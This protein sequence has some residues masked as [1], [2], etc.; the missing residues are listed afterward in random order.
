MD[1]NMKK[2]IEKYEMDFEKISSKPTWEQK[3]IEM[4]K[5][6]QKL[7]YYIE[8]RCAMKEG[9]EY[10]GSEHMPDVSER[11]SYA[12]AIPRHY[13]QTGNYMTSRSGHYPIEPYYDDR[14]SGRRYYDSER[15]NAVYELR[16]MMDS[17]SDPELKMALQGV[18]HELEQK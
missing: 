9:N 18:I 6:L 16:R 14:G 3:D 8:V 5:D 10:P 2:L 13:S 1:S 7:M 4:M 17:K 11:R 15:D 12:Q